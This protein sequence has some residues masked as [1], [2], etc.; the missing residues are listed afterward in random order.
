MYKAWHFQKSGVG[1][2]RTGLRNQR[3]EVR[4]Q[5]T[6][7]R[8]QKSEVRNCT[9]RIF[10]I[11]IRPL[12]SFTCSLPS[13]LCFLVT[14]FRIPHFQFPI[15]F[16][17]ICLLSFPVPINL[18]QYFGGYIISQLHR[19]IGMFGSQIILPF[20]QVGDGQVIVGRRKI[21]IEFNGL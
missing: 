7:F 1:T 16:S 15:Q 9:I 13:V 4:G 2:Q 8:G 11:N 5:K 6:D 3:S 14:G 18:F 21:R 20:F 19:F 17:V 12:S 10:F